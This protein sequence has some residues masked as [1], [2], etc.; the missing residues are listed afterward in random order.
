M[1]ISMRRVYLMEWTLLDVYNFFQ[2]LSPYYSVSFGF[3]C[4]LHEGQLKVQL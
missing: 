3:P 1:E 4:R 2:M